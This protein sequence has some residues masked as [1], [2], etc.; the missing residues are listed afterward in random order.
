MMQFRL[1]EASIRNRVGEQ[2][3]K[4][5]K[6]YFQQDAIMSP[7]I[8]GNMLKAKCWGSMP[9]PYHVWVQL[10][11]N[12]I[13]SGECSCPVGDGGYCKHVAALLLM[14]LHKPDSF[15]EVEPLD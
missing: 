13:D 3:F 6:R 12:D 15:Q 9:Q 10:G 7:W 4:R 5:G 14:W 1:T 8:Q 11:V 2:S